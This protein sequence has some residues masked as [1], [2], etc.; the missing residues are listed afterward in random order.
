MNRLKWIKNIMVAKIQ[1]AL[2]VA[3]LAILLGLMGWLLGGSQLALM[4]IAGVVTMYFF[5][6]MVSPAVLMRF[7]AGR[8]LLPQEA[9]HLFDILQRL[10]QRAGLARLPRLFYLPTDAMLAYT[11]GPRNNA[12]IAVSKG[13]IQT[14]S[15]QELGAVL[16][17]E[18]SHIRHNDTRMMA[19]AGMAGQMTRILS[20]F[21]QFML[22]VSL[23]LMLAGQ[24]TINWLAI[25]LLIFSPML[26]SLIQLALSRTREYNAD[27]SAAELTGN[28]NALA[29]AL[30]KIDMVHK[31]LLY[32]LVWPMIPRVPQA[33]WLRTHP[34]TKERVRR[35]LEIRDDDQMTHAYPYYNR[36]NHYQI[37]I[38][39]AFVDV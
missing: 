23:P 21:G 37:P 28:P 14:L 36:G 31:N 38:H 8:Q 33:S 20:I 10:S 16:A 4:L 19:F 11:V 22:V 24:A 12:A 29:S 18:I 35:L 15:Q 1:S 27:M 5:G 30:A 3:S 13:L 25:S 26:T 6:S 32:R 34:P 39:R 9:P 17:H 7:N 2:L